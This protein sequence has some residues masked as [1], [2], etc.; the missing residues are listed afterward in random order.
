MT[1]AH[2]VVRKMAL[3][4]LLGTG[5]LPVNCICPWLLNPRTLAPIVH[6]E[7]TPPPPKG[8]IIYQTDLH[9]P[10]ELYL[11]DLRTRQSRRLTDNGASDTLPT[12]IAATGKIA[13]LSD[14]DGYW[15]IFIMNL[16]SDQT[17]SLSLQN[18]E[19]WIDTPSWSPDGKRIVAPVAEWKICDSPQRC[20]YD[21]YLIESATGAMT[22]LTHTPDAS[23]WTPEWSPDGQRIAFASNRDGDSEIFIMD[24]GTRNIRQLTHNRC[25]DGRPRWSPDGKW[26]LYETDCEG[27]DWDLYLIDAD[28]RNPRP[29]TVNATHDYAPAWSP[30]GR[31]IAYAGNADGDYEIYLITPEGKHPQ[32]LTWNVCCDD[33]YPVWI[34]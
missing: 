3:L 18:P 33:T 34:P 31:W 9:G 14:R 17:V 12:Y 27:G 22:N 1:L 13:F 6:Q 5:L 29:V 19:V 2:P 4:A 15:K 32:R 21:L 23:E 7:K 11:L 20:L 10:P 25:Y 28:G 16:E 8:K 30:D 26:I 24:E